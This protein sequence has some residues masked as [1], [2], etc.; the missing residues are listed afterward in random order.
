MNL[1]TALRA[2]NEKGGFLRRAVGAALARLTEPVPPHGF[3]K[4]E[5]AP[6]TESV[7]GGIV[8]VL[9]QRAHDTARTPPGASCSD[10]RSLRYS[11]QGTAKAVQSAGL[12]LSAASRSDWALVSEKPAA[13]GNGETETTRKPHGGSERLNALASVRDDL[14]PQGHRVPSDSP[15]N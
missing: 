3:G 1:A 15:S 6:W 13:R 8:P 14:A 12:T 10:Q 2:E 4:N 5:T 11:C 9:T 7:R